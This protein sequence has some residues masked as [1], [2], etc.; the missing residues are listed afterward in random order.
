MLRRALEINK[1]ALGENDPDVVTS[2]NNLANLLRAQNKLAEAEPM[3]RRAL[4]IWENALGED[5][6]NV[7][8]SRGNLFVL[9]D[10]KARQLDEDGASDPAALAQIYTETADMLA[11]SQS[12]SQSPSLSQFAAKDEDVLRC[13]RRAAELAGS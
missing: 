3:L 13:R 1:I 7:A 8:T 6:P 5:H 4:A 11:F 10:A 9:L 2:Y 12:L